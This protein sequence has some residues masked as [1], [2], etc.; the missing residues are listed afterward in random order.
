MAMK[1]LKNKSKKSY[2]FFLIAIFIFAF[3]LRVMFLQSDALTFGYDQAR[4]ALVAKQILSGDLKIQGPPSSQPGLYHGVLYYYL[5]A[6]AYLIGNG[7]PIITAYYL[8]FLN[9]LAVIIIFYIAKLATN[10]IKLSLLSSFLFAISFESTQYATWASNPTIAVWTVPLMYLGLWIWINRESQ[11]KNNLG[12]ILAGIGLGLSIQAEIFLLYHIVP[13]L[14]WLTI[15]KSN[16]TKK[17]L[18]VFIG[19]L[20]LVVLS[21]ILCEFKFGFN[22]LTA[23]KSL[24]NSSS[25]NLAYAKSVGDYLILYLNQIGRIF[26]FNTYPGNIGYG[27]T[28][29][30]VLGVYSLINWKKNPYPAFLATWLFSHLSVVTVG[31]TSTPFLM[32]GIGPAVSL[33]LGFYIYKL[34]NKQTLFAFLLLL[35][36]V[37]GNLSYVFSQNKL[38]ST[39]FSIQKDMLLSK[40]INA[41]DYTYQ[42][43]EGKPFSINSLTSPLWI[44]IVWTYLYKWYGMKTYG[45]LPYWHGKDQIG[46]L[47]SLERIENPLETSFLI[48][49]PMAGIPT[50]Y[51][52][53]TIGEEDVDTVIVEQKSF[54]EIVVQKRKS[55]PSGSR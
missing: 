26:A 54:G 5:L 12:P 41:I 3:F 1:N 35:V 55:A 43:A 51:L 22:S 24:A 14:I 39:L 29:V 47:D 13:L 19:T 6:P 44:N 2:N 37:Y 7:S 15:R 50:R 33:I 20:I 36:I 48:L 21:L 49:E 38:G 30:I 8:A 25:G 32:V 4:D 52:E 11:T 16:I 28:S 17:S 40:Q 34:F 46:Q 27:G 53:E 9:A 31:G 23:V 42:L 10:N 45:Y 18:F